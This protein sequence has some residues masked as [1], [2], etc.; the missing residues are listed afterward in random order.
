MQGDI[1]QLESLMANQV[2]VPRPQLAATSRPTSDSHISIYNEDD[3]SHLLYADNHP[4]HHHYPH[5]HHHQQHS[6]HKQTQFVHPADA[7]G[8]IIINAVGD[9]MDFNDT[10]A[11]SDC[12]S[13]YSESEASGTDVTSPL[14]PP[15]SASEMMTMDDE[16]ALEAYRRKGRRNALS[17][18]F[19]DGFVFPVFLGRQDEDAVEEEEDVWHFAGPA[20]SPR[21]A[22]ARA[23]LSLV[24]PAVPVK[25]EEEEEELAVPESRHV[26]AIGGPAMS[27][28]PAPLETTENDWALENM[29]WELQMEED[30][31]RAREREGGVLSSSSAAASAA[32][33]NV[34]EGAAVYEMR[35]V[36]MIE[37]P[38]MSWWPT[39]AEGMEYEWSERF[40]E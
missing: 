1:F 29:E 20:K 19:E 3:L 26:D 18:K 33:V 9:E 6:S 27:W 15:L 7:N 40:H 5:H 10:P 34:M 11:T 17:T 28:W 37:G 38:L 8:T 2:T 4:H 23:S 39:P 24:A 21:E 35:P 36:E 31:L 14:T 12:G 22:L 25:K 32:A 16:A 30:K 13:C